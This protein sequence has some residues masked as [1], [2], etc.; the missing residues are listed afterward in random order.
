MIRSKSISLL[1]VLSVALFLGACNRKLIQAD[2]IEVIDLQQQVPVLINKSDNPLARILVV[3]NSKASNSTIREVKVHIGGNVAESE[4]KDLKL[5]VASSDGGWNMLNYKTLFS[6]VAGAKNNAVFKGSF[7]VSGDT[8]FFLLTCTLSPEADLAHTISARATSLRLN[9]GTS[10]SIARGQNAIDQRLGVGVRKHMDDNVHTYRIPGLA[11]TT[12]GTLL[13]IY[14][15]RRDKSRDL[16]GDIDI[17]V[18]RSTDKGASWET[19]RIA[20]DKKNWGGLPEK[21]NGISDANILVDEKTGTIYIAG[22]WMYG[23][24]DEDGKWI[25]GLTEE[26]GKWGHQWRDKASQPG[27]DVKETSQ[28]LLTKSVDDGK[29][30]SEPV[31]LT[32]MCKKKEWW[33]WAPAPGH[34][35]SLA[36]GTLV[37]PTQGRDQNGHPFSNITYSKDGGNIWVTSEPAYS[38]TTENMAVQ[39]SDGSIMLNMR[40]NAN[41]G[42]LGDDNGRVISTTSDL[43]Q[44]WTEHPTSKKALIEPTCMASIH[45]HYYIQNGQKKSVLFFSNPNS[46]EGRHHMT[47]KVSFDD[48]KTWP[49]KYWLLLD[50]GKGRGYSCLTSVDQ[51]TI[52]ILYEGSQADMTF[53]RIS[54]TDWLD[55]PSTGK[56]NQR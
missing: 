14:D 8:T 53:Q 27:F 30:W 45:K 7:E 34:G 56:E 31:N 11:T 36:D 55:I 42:N 49:K 32:K 12:K 4:V 40:Y 1:L 35:I 54:L 52:G 24:L 33:L 16:Q 39:L 3:R 41:R 15:V 47:I 51:E 29:T 44:T 28:F 38:N 6:E 21:F 22:L 37:F 25:E 5:W 10:A 9:D 50:E 23:L 17:G 20:M 43:G 19:M 18:S 26:S 13:G 46:K 2:G 48:G